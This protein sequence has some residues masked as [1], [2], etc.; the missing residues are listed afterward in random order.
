MNGDISRSSP[1]FFVFFVVKVFS[2]SGRADSS[3]ATE[4]NNSQE[5]RWYE[6]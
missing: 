6:K 2:V 5:G 1:S 3:V 4:I